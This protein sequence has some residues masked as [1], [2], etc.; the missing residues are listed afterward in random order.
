MQP[1]ACSRCSEPERGGHSG[2]GDRDRPR[3]LRRKRKRE[4]I[5]PGGNGSRRTIAVR[6][7]RLYRT[8][9]AKC[10]NHFSATKLVR[11]F[12]PATRCLTKAVSVHTESA[13][14]FA[15]P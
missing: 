8:H 14:V 4:P 12:A 15:M 1:S 2:E 6:L 9:V 5:Y 10:A 11:E 3:K 13:L 7:N